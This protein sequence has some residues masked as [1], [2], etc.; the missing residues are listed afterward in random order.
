MPYQHRRVE[1]SAKNEAFVLDILFGRD[2]ASGIPQLY[3][4]AGLASQI[5]DFSRHGDTD[6]LKNVAFLKTVPLA[7]EQ[8]NDLQQLESTIMGMCQKIFDTPGFQDPKD[9]P[10]HISVYPKDIR[11][12]YELALRLHQA[13]SEHTTPVVVN[14]IASALSPESENLNVLEIV[15]PADEFMIDIAMEVLPE[16]QLLTT[17]YATILVNTCKKITQS[18]DLVTPYKDLSKTELEWLGVLGIL[19]LQLIK[20]RGKLTAEQVKWIEELDSLDFSLL[21]ERKKN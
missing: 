9:N 15:P 5:A 21:D 7:M 18:A 12:G 3:V 19:N 2:E 17:H 20:G 16:L 8:A 1:F 6:R 10:Q 4:A 14:D 11:Q 13:A